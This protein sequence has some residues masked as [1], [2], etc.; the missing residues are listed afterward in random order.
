MAAFGGIIPCTTGRNAIQ[1]F[2]GPNVVWEEM[3]VLTCMGKKPLRDQYKM[4]SKQAG[5]GE[6]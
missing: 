3:K 1:E 5:R 2:E 6:H 4:C